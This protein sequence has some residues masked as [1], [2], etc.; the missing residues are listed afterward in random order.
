MGRPDIKR[1]VVDPLFKD[2]R[3]PFEIAE[4][5][6]LKLEY[7]SKDELVADVRLNCGE[8]IITVFCSTILKI[9]RS[10]LFFSI[11]KRQLMK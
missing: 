6:S 7:M 2:A 4:K 10:S 3:L 5:L 11:V 1:I 8:D 9:I